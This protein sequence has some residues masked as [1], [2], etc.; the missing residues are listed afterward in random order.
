M[1]TIDWSQQGLNVCL[2]TLNAA[3]ANANEKALFTNTT[4]RAYS[5]AEELDR[6]EAVLFRKRLDYPTRREFLH[7]VR[8]LP[9]DNKAR[10]ANGANGSDAQAAKEPNRI[11]YTLAE[12]MAGDLLE[13]YFIKGV[14]CP[15]EVCVIFGESGSLK[16]FVGTDATLHFSAGKEWCG[17]RVHGGAV[18][19][20]LG[21]G[22]AGFKKR[23]RAWVLKHR[24]DPSALKVYV[25]PR[26]IDLHSGPDELQLAYAE[27][28]KALGCRVALSLID[29]YSTNLGPGDEQ[30]N[31]DAAIVLRNVREANGAERGSLFVHHVGH[32]DKLRERGAYQLRAN[33][34]ERFLVQRDDANRGEIITLTN[35]KQKDRAELA[36]LRFEWQVFNLGTDADGDP[37]SSLVLDPTEREPTDANADTTRLTDKDLAALDVLWK[38]AGKNGAYVPADDWR[39]ALI[40]AELI[41][42]K[43]DDANRRTFSRIAKALHDGKAKLINAA[44]KGR[45]TQYSPRSTDADPA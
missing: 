22:A 42:G 26:P 2:V 33:A 43:T 29:T 32:G 35:E 18:L 10:S 34:D 1:E 6:K 24:V 28:E 41:K 38:L 15:G 19:I 40:K 7:E 36:P 13:P 27:A 5:R 9:T 20:V 8:Q 17:R 11:G 16:S 25:Y 12:A 37:L 39:K 31:K 21:E 3:L 23:L 14:I 30:S 45:A 4:L 44:G